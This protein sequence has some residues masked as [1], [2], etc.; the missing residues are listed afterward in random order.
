[1]I[2]V[3]A[4]IAE[5]SNGFLKIIIQIHWQLF[6]CEAMSRG[7]GKMVKPSRET[8]ATNGRFGVS[9]NERG[10]RGPL[11]EELGGRDCHGEK[12]KHP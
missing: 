10:P 3:Q 12:D 6:I 9:K 1:M 5:R 11:C 2:W 8:E 7:S 4:R